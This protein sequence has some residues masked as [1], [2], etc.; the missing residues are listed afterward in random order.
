VAAALAAGPAAAAWAGAAGCSPGRALRPDQDGEQDVEDGGAG[1]A[2]QRAG[3]TG[4][5]AAQAL[6]EQ[7]FS[8]QRKAA[9]QPL[10]RILVTSASGANGDG[11]GTLL[12]FS[13]GGEPAGP[14]SNDLRITDP[15]GLSLSPAG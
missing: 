10:R 2:G 13:A 6:T 12:C 8:R 14:F 3:G 15:R 5:D 4:Q 7:H 11:Y 9:R 1:C